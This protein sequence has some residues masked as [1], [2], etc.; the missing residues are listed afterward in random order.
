[1]FIHTDSMFV[2]ADARF[3]DCVMAAKPDRKRSRSTQQ[4]R[5]EK[6][7]A[8]LLEAARLLFARQGFAAT[9]LDDIL[10][11]TKLTRGALYHHFNGK[12]E[13][14]RAVFEEQEKILTAAV[15]RAAAEK[16]S[17][18][19]AFRAGCDGFLEACLDPATQRIILIDAPAVLGWDVMREI[20]SRYALALLRAGLERT[21]AEGKLA[22]RPVEPLAMIL[23]GALSEAAM[24]IARAPDPKSAAG[25]ARREIERLLKALA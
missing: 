25:D 24:A 8:A 17:A 7:V 20:E 1:M 4:E 14:F 2:K 5:S 13:L 19:Q 3:Y 11:A 16:R 21:M 23:L 18:W 22:R 9:S 15:A 12:T 6:T 10:A